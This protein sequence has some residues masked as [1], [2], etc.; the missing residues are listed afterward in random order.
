M[1][2]FLVVGLLVRGFLVVGFWVFF[3]GLFE[4]FFVEGFLV[5][6]LV[7]GISVGLC[8]LE[9]AV[10]VRVVAELLGETVFWHAAGKP[11]P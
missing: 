4:G 7:V 1:R 5:I 3:V 9:F 8:V 11:S 10:G 2:G 6:G